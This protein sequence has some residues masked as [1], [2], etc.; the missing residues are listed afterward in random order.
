VK[1][2]LIFSISRGR[3]FY[4]I[5]NSFG[6][7]RNLYSLGGAKCSCIGWGQNRCFGTG[8]DVGLE[9]PDEEEAFFT[10]GNILV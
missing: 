3:E 7:G 1:K 8:R 10:L 9:R 2:I 6:F 5:H 4:A